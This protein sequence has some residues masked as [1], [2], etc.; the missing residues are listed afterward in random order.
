MPEQC[1][2]ECWHSGGR[3]STGSEKLERD[4]QGVRREEPMRLG[5]AGVHVRN[6]MEWGSGVHLLTVV[7]Q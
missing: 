6:D 1:Q 2:K 4:D 3:S 7:G 5:L